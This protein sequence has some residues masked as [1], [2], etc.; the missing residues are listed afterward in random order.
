[1]KGL[2]IPVRSVVLATFLTLGAAAHLYASKTHITGKV[3]LSSG[4]TAHSLWVVLRQDEAETGRFLTGD[5]GKYYIGNQ[6]DGT[7]TI[8][9]KRRE[10]K[11]YSGQVTLPRDQD[12]D[13]PLP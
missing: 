11:L 8:L 10:R 12:H 3:F 6:E 5:D 13:I 2:T 1:M 4:R 9:V 7:Y